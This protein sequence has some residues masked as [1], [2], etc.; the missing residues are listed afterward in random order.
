MTRS[1]LRGSLGFAAVSLAAYAVWAFAGKGLS[2]H[3]KEGGF[4][5]VMAVVFV[6]LSGLALHKLVDGPNSLPRF[7]KVFIPAFLAY[8]AVWCGAWFTLGWVKGEW[9]GSLAGSAA[10]AAVA[11][12]LLGNLK[13]VGKAALV[14]FIGHSAGY[15]LGAPVCYALKGDWRVAGILA[16]GLLYG[17]GF[18][19]GIG[20]AFHVFQ[21]KGEASAAS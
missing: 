19:A 18:G 15:F 1:I 20:Y 2:A 9:L 21:R 5:A 13:P 7:L 10:F 8:A 6:A 12:A 4:Y 11:G 17:L 14:L 16:W 3:L